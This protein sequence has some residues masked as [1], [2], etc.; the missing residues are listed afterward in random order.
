MKSEPLLNFD[1][2][3][4]YVSRLQSGD[5]EIVQETN[6]PIVAGFQRV[7][8]GNILLPK[9]DAKKLALFILDRP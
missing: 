4:G 9:A 5:I 2:G 6:L 3:L 8:P 7:L 1:N